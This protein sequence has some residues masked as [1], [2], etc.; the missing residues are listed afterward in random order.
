MSITALAARPGTAV[1]PVCSMRSAREPSAAPMAAFLQRPTGGVVSVRIARVV[2]RADQ[3]HAECDSRVE[4]SARHAE[5]YPSVHRETEA[6]RQRNVRER[7]CVGCLCDTAITAAA[8]CSRTGATTT[9]LSGR[10][11]VG[12]LSC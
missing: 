4:E 10:G 9:F 12:D 8:S 5:E 2:D 7:G 1:E 6:E 11:C 3:R